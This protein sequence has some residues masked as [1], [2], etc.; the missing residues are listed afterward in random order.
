MYKVSMS[1]FDIIYR[2]GG[3]VHSLKNR[4]PSQVNLDNWGGV[5]YIIVSGVTRVLIGGGGGDVYSY[6]RVLPD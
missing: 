6:I 4:P 2:G 3:K 5:T 1:Y